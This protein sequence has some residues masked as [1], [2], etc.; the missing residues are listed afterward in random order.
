MGS[1]IGSLLEAPLHLAA[2][3]VQYYFITV[4]SLSV[5]LIIGTIEY[6]YRFNAYQ[7]EAEMAA[8]N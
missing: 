1:G 7:P 2:N 3:L 8:P 6:L 4:C 5:V